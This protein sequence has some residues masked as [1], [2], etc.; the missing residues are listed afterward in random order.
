MRMAVAPDSM[1]ERA[2]LTLGKVPL[3]IARSFSA[4]PT[5]RAV[6]VAQ[7]LGVFAALAQRPQSAERLAEQLGAQP[8]TLRM[9]LDLLT[10]ERILTLS[11]AD[12]SLG[13]EGR[14]WLDPASPTYVGTFVE[15][16][17]E[18]WGWWNDLERFV[19]N[20]GSID[21]HAMA[22]DDPGW[23][24]YIR[25]QYELARL[26]AAEVAKGVKL[27]PDAAS[28]LDVA[29]GHG[30][31]SAALCRRNPG[32]RATV[33]DLAPSC[34]VGEAIIAENGMSDAVRHV[35]GDMFAADLGGPHDGALAFS[36]LHHLSPAQRTE[37][38]ARIGDA[39][40]P[41][42]PVAIIDMF[43]PENDAP[44]RASA[45]IFELFFYITSGSDVPS[46]SELEGHLSEAGFGAPRRVNLRS[47]PDLRLYTAAK[48]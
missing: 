3:P 29:G 13:K 18:Y 31:F 19:R 24:V 20:G 4:M 25:G 48:R 40:K 1:L 37:L 33:V 15:H 27:A 44:R 5:A 35:V 47:I 43:R 38:L 30:W 32:L 16:T 6:Q 21:F 10:G 45:A 11:G 17:A 28:L 41:G 23:E 39:L 12:Y 22:D 36:I 42:A 26:S 7:R 14:V 34:A 46:Q 9:L 2:G 8:Q